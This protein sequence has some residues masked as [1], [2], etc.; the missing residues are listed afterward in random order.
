MWYY[1]LSTVVI[2]GR[3]DTMQCFSNFAI[4]TLPLRIPVPSFSD[5]FQPFCK[6]TGSDIKPFLKWKFWFSW[7]GEKP[8]TQLFLVRCWS[9]GII[10]SSKALLECWTWK[11]EN[12]VWF[13]ALTFTNSIQVNNVIGFLIYKVE[14]N[15]TVLERFFKS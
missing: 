2:W 10:L 9:T 3:C 15:R 8:K 1:L 5:I 11:K 14:I 6:M 12:L 4:Q 7:F 13:E